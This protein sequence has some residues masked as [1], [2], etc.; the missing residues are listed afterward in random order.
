M[1]NRQRNGIF[2]LFATGALL[3]IFPYYSGSLTD[4]SL[5]E[6]AQDSFELTYVGVQEFETT[7]MPK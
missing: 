5:E 6:Y 3:I 4:K 1:N 7:S 2:I